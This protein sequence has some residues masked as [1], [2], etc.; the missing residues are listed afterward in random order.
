MNINTSHICCVIAIILIIFYMFNTSEPFWRG[1][2]H[3]G[4]RGG[5]P[6]GR[7]LRGNYYINDPV[8]YSPECISVN[9]NEICGPNRYKVGI[10]SNDSGIIDEWRCCL[11]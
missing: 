11:L 7:R 3:G 5:W 8:Y 2:W 1:R 6:R 9:K 10:D 4:W